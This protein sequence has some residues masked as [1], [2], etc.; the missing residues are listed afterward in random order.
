MRKMN[1]ELNQ[2]ER[3]PVI[4]SPWEVFKVLLLRYPDAVRASAPVNIAEGIGSTQNALPF[5]LP[6]MVM[7]EP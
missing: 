6:E 3:Q 2:K 7:T 5:I 1:S 4:A